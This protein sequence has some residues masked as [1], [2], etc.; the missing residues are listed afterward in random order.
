LPDPFAADRQA[1]KKISGSSF[2]RHSSPH[3]ALFVD[4]VLMRSQFEAALRSALKSQAAFIA[5]P[6]EL[7]QGV[8]LQPGLKRTEVKFVEDRSC[9]HC[10]GVEVR[11]QGPLNA[12]VRGQVTLLPSGLG[13]IATARA[14]FEIAVNAEK[15]VRDVVIRPQRQKSWKGNVQI[16]GLPPGVKDELRGMW[17]GQLQ[18]ALRAGHIPEIVVTR[19]GPDATVDLVDVQARPDPRGLLVAFFF[20]VANPGAVKSI[21]PVK[22]GFMLAVP[23]QT[24]LALARAMVLKKGPKEGL[25]LEAKKVVVD[26][27]A[28]RMR[29]RAWRVDQDNVHR[30]FDVSGPFQRT[31]D[32]RLKAVVRSVEKVEGQALPP[33]VLGMLTRSQL[34][35]Q[36]A[37]SLNMVVPAQRE[38]RVG[39]TTYKT[40]A[41]R[42]LADDG[43][44]YI[45]GKVTRSEAPPP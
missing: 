39:E 26:D 33:D 5:L 25:L 37:A 34:L 24:V 30:D 40:E 13:Y 20:A 3:A 15:G 41:T 18:K 8:K 31:G 36:I 22:N 29:L 27:D 10:I 12:D 19:L 28:Y 1:L 2:T 35:E 4:S 42:I 9:S 23:Q 44:L 21:P 11:I 45:E 32:A 43:V 38:D 6:P 17:A 14:V 7:G 16:T